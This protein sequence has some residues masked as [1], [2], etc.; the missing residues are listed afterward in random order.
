MTEVIER[1]E[2]SETAQPVTRSYAEWVKAFDSV[3]ESERL[4]ISR[5]IR[6]LRRHPLISIVLPVYNP[7]PAHL[8]AAI[9]SVRSQ[10]YQNWELCIA[11]D[12]STDSRVAS[13]LR[14]TAANDS[15]CKVILRKK[16]GHIAACSN[17]ALTLATGE[18]VALLDQ[19][20]LLAEHALAFAAATILRHPDAGLIYSDEDKIDDTGARSEP[21]FKSDWNPALFV[22]QNFVSHLGVYR[23]ELLEKI[24]GFREGFDGS[25]DYDLALRASEHLRVDQIVHI[26]RVLY[27]WRKI[28]GSLAATSEAKNYAH[29]SARRAIREHLRRCKIKAEVV[30]SPEN[31]AAHR[32]IYE[33]PANVP[34]VSIVIPTR[35]HPELLR[36]CVEGI[37]S[38]T[39]YPRFRFVIVDNDSQLTKTKALLGELRKAG[40]V[41][42]VEEKSAFNFSRLINFGAAAAEG[43]V[44]ALLNDDVIPENA[45]WLSE[46]VSQLLQPGV[47]AVGARLWYPDRRLQHGGVILGLGGV[48]GH[49]HYRWPRDHPGY[50]NR[51]TLQQD[52]SAVTAACMLVR[53]SVFEELGGFDERDLGVS[54]NDIDFCLRMAQR[55]LRIVW[56]PQACL[57]HHESASRG[58]EFNEEQKWVFRREAVWMQEKWAKKLARDPYYNPNLSLD[59]EGGF[60]LAW[61]PRLPGLSASLNGSYR[62]DLSELF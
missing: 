38:R 52:L 16:N 37:R 33:L 3:E 29:D 45:E 56:T 47:G 25:Q 23:R 21:Y 13:L 58:R 8:R 60:T 62:R 31:S 11:D 12:A 22:V 4:V 10:L 44:L 55:G 1:T 7:E 14:E 35:D 19:D 41:T 2:S 9:E 51:A 54:F 50:F 53:K 59:E 28:A 39:K 6:T 18:W 27:H 36:Q 48:A 46:M 61:P 42:V 32:I 57:V 43:E 49:A 26:P 30:P 34:L 17:S 40:D 15:R 24:G 5:H 20:D